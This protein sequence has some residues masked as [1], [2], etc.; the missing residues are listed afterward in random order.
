MD[1]DVGLVFR[2]DFE[3]NNVI[4]L[5]VDYVFFGG[6]DE[7]SGDV[8]IAIE[9]DDDNSCYFSIIFSIIVIRIFS[10]ISSDVVR[11]RVGSSGRNISSTEVGSGFFDSDFIFSFFGF[12]IVISR[13][14]LFEFS[15]VVLGVVVV[16]S[17]CA[18]AV[19]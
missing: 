11:F 15:D 17:S 18:S 5:F 12:G 9:E 16:V 2:L 4:Y 13:E 10:F 14:F 19:S 6:S 3:D 8:I 1:F 7:I